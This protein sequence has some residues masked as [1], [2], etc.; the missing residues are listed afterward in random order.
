[1][2]TPHDME[3]HWVYLT[4]QPKI[5]GVTFRLKLYGVALSGPAPWREIPTTFGY[6]QRGTRRNKGWTVQD[7]HGTPLTTLP[8]ELTS[9][10]AR[11]AA[12]MIL[13]SLKE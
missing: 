11:N 6:L 1:M 9:E 13:L 7:V 5:R 2:T 12:R 10:E 4:F 3:Y 8:N